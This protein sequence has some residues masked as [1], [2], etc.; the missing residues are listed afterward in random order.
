M[1]TCPRKG[2]D[3]FLLNTIK[4]SGLELKR[5]QLKCR[6][7]GGGCLGV[8]GPCTGVCYCLTVSKLLQKLPNKSRRTS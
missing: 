1:H 3:G 4:L 5:C 8:S 7:L 2:R 6:G